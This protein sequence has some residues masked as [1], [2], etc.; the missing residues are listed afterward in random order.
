[1]KAIIQNNKYDIKLEASDWRFS[2]AIVGLI[3]YL[4]YHQFEYETKHDYILYNSLDIDEKK[5]L[6]FVEYKYG[7]ELHHKLVESILSQDK[8]TEEQAK[9]LNDKLKANKV[10]KDVFNKVEFDGSSKDEILNILNE[11]RYKLIRETYGKK[12][13]GYAN[14][15]PV[16]M[17]ASVELLKPRDNYCRLIGYKCPDE[18]RKSKTIGYNFD[19]NN[20]VAKDEVEFDFIPFAFIGSSESFFINDNFT[21]NKLIQ[22]NNI[23]TKKLHDSLKEDENN[24]YK[25]TRKIIFKT[26]LESSDFIDYDVEIIT[27]DQAN[28]YFETLYIRKDAIKILKKL[29]DKKENFKYDSICF[30][31]RITDKYIINIQKEIINN[32][33]NNIVI[34]EF[35]ELILKDKERKDK[36]TSNH[37]YK[38]NQMIKINILIRGEEDMKDKL[39]GAY[40]CAKKISQALPENK[41]SSYR[42]K[43]ISSIVFKDYDRACQILLQLSNYSGIEFGFVYDLFGNFEENKDLAYTFINALTKETNKMEN[44]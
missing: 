3:Q 10:M 25:D 22:S 31:Y 28:E 20:Y 32:I 24:N 40:A 8:I 13:N 36:K 15:I 38:I 21:I 14:Y 29:N 44:N 39:K 35:I 17:K 4:E 43:L 12:Q 30:L 37:S 23:L 26:I 34:D 18:A 9:I 5:Y 42:Q 19:K 6:E 41:L 16:N 11:N 33:L 7:D 27:K 1:M 2:A